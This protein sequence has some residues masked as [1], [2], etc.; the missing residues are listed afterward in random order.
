[1]DSRGAVTSSTTQLDGKGTGVRTVRDYRGDSGGTSIQ[2]WLDIPTGQGSA[3]Q[4]QK[5][6][7][8][9]HPRIGDGDNQTGQAWLPQYDGC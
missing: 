2:V 7:Q 8:H 1:M 5:D 3:Q 4:P 9:Q 6:T